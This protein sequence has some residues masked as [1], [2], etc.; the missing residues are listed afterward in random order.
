MAIIKPFQGY[1]PSENIAKY[2]SSP[3]YDVMTS[4]EAREMVKNNPDSFLRI[5]KPE[6]D[7]PINNE[8]KGNSLHKHGSKNLQNL[9]NQKKINQDVKPYFYLYQINMGS[10]TQTGIM[11]AVSVNDYNKEKIKKHEYT[12]S[13]KEKDRTNHIDILNGNTGPVFLTFK[14]D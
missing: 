1:C 3:P 7:F 12:R 5:I 13:E 8:P 9:I 6:V 4:N 14:N 10:H 2:I 11:A